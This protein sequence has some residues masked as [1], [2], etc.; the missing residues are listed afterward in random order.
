MSCV[1]VLK[2]ARLGQSPL[3]SLVVRA[4]TVSKQRTCSG[5]GIQCAAPGCCAVRCANGIKWRRPTPR[6][7][8]AAHGSF[9]V[10]ARGARASNSARTAHHGRVEVR[11]AQ[12]WEAHLEG[13]AV[14]G[15]EPH[16]RPTLRATEWDQPDDGFPPPSPGDAVTNDGQA[17]FEPR[18]NGLGSQA[19]CLYCGPLCRPSVLSGGRR[20]ARRG[21]A[22]SSSG[23]DICAGIVLAAPSV[24]LGRERP[25]SQRDHLR[26]VTVFKQR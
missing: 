11:Q 21:P 9:S 1:D 24:R 19:L 16:S 6:A 5:A 26:F 13:C 20:K 10:S 15:R 23:A 3:A 18:S 7:H 22:S 2:R 14:A 4:V 12:C 25:I 17:S 8:Q